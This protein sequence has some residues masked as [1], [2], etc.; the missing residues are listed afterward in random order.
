MPRKKIDP[1][2]KEETNAIAMIDHA[3]A[4]G[5]W[6]DLGSAICA[7]RDARMA[8]AGAAQNG[9]PIRILQ[10]SEECDSLKEGGRY[11]IQPPLV[12]R[13]AALLDNLCKSNGISAIVACREPKT[14]LGLCP[15]VALGSG[16]T[17][18]VQVEPPKN[19]KKPTCAWFDHALEEL[20]DHVLEQLH[21]Q[22]TDQR[23][24]DYL[25]AHFSA[26]PTHVGAYR[27]AIA[28]CNTLERK[29]V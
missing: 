4:G 26:I 22:K 8:R 29:S 19:P 21:L 15:I 27:A 10:E 1:W 28:L 24:L 3:R 16:V 12:A 7:L 6:K 18:R 5:K 14:A 23:Q 13:D 20:G 11:L 2:F 9:K 25:L 17:V